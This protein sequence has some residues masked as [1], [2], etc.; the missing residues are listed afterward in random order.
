MYDVDDSGSINIT[1]M[2]SIIAT[3]DELEGE[4]AR[5]GKDSPAAR[6]C[7]CATAI[8]YQLL[9]TAHAQL[10]AFTSCC[11]LRMCNS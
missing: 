8:V 4:G 2:T 1:E 5:M 3:M 11:V 7:T 6:Y 9:R 10:R